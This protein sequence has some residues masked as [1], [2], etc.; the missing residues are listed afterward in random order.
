MSAKKK[1]H[2][3]NNRVVVS[4]PRPWSKKEEEVLHCLRQ[5]GIPYKIIA[6]ELHRTERS[7]KRKFQN[8]NWHET[9]LYDLNKAK[10]GEGLKRA[11]VEKIASAQDKR[12]SVSKM[13]G[14][15]VGDR[16]AQAVSALPVVKKPVYIKSTKKGKKKHSDEDVGLIFSDAH[17]GH[18]HSLEETGGISEYNIDVFH[19]RMDNLKLALADIT[20]LHSQL[21]RL[22]TL[23][24]FSLGDIVAGMNSVGAWSPTYINMPIYDQV[25]A[26]VE[27]ISDAIYYWLGIFDNIVFYGI[28]GNHGKCM[29]KTTKILTPYGY[30]DYKEID[31]E[32]YCDFLEKQLGM[33]FGAVAHVHSYCSRGSCRGWTCPLWND[34]R[35]SST[36]HSA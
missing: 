25:I 19:A 16:I 36:L 33:F 15:I 22:P 31:E 10:L 34:E 5:E 12:L 27:A 11:Y 6:A 35:R 26:G 23:H 24:I 30:K 13:I 32:K 9:G 14:D 1:P 4:S 7:C 3:Q 17:I 8:T 29:S 21:Y 20:E 28:I 2:K 18:H